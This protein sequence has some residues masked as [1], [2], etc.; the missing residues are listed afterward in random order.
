MVSGEVMGKHREP[1]ELEQEP[2]NKSAT[3]GEPSKPHWGSKLWEWTGFGEKKL[4]DWLQLLS[5]LAIPIVLTVAGFWFT[6]Q[7]ARHQQDIEER[8]A[9][10]EQLLEEQRAQDTAL[11]TYL[12]QMG[13]LILEENLRNSERRSEVRTLA[14]ARTL[15]V[16]GRLDPERKRSAIQF[17]YESYLIDKADPIVDLSNADLR[18]VDLRLKELINTDLNEVD[19]SKANLSNAHLDD[20]NLINADLSDASLINADLSD[21]SL[22]NA[23]L[24]HANLTYATLNRTNLCS[25]ILS[26]ADLNGASL[27][28]ADLS[29]AVL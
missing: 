3:E 18:S 26:G 20:A 21:A 19:L 4:W 14:R 6:S 15:T 16:L 28:K 9:K 23:D 2:G 11:Q 24:S 25:A 12:D 29:H 10:A 13:A 5:A 27:I 8:R 22:I 1:V 17:L 7:Q